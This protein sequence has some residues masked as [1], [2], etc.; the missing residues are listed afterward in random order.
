MSEFIPKYEDE[1]DSK[2]DYFWCLYCNRTYKKTEYKTNQ[3]DHLCPYEDCDGSA[4]FDAWDW[5]TLVES[6]NYPKVPI[7]GERYSLYKA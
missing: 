6:N 2:S 7:K 1:D 3:G 5:Y 4:I